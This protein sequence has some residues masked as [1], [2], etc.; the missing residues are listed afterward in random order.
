MGKKLGE[1]GQGTVYLARSPERIQQIR[2]DLDELSLH[3]R[4]ISNTYG[5]EDLAKCIVRLGSPDPSEDL[6][7]LKKFDIPA[8]LE[9]GAKLGFPVPAAAAEGMQALG[10]LEE[11]VRALRELQ[12]PAILKLLSA[13]PSKRFIVTEYH[14]NGT[15]DKHLDRYKGKVSQALEAFRP[16][17]DAVCAIHERGAIHRDIK[18]KNIFVATDGR[19][20]LGDFGIVFFANGNRQTKTFEKV[21]TFHWMAP[22]AYRNERL[23]IEEITPALDIFPL[24]KV[25]WAMISGRDGFPLW[26]CDRDENNLEKIFPHDAVMHLV[27]SLLKKCIVREEKDCKLSAKELL[28]EVDGLI[29]SSAFRPVGKPD[30]GPWLCRMCGRGH[31]SQFGAT[32]PLVSRLSSTMQREFTISVCDKCGHTETF[33]QR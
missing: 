9:Q 26:E 6:G 13:N 30:Q 7:A 18:T 5:S 33:L 2:N 19:L 17:V 24:A 22:W 11:E 29:E 21:G 20:V 23:A 1:G 12:H 16:L 15:L 8:G 3:L 25:L 14:P 28:A 4:S 32:N 31:Y 10:R 27:N